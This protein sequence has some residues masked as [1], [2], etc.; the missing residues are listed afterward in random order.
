MSVMKIRLFMVTF[1][2]LAALRMSALAEAALPEP[3]PE[4]GGLR[5]RL[6]IAPRIEAG[7]EGY[8]V[9]VEAV[10][11]AKRAI[12]LRAGWWHETEQGD[13]KD[14]IEA[15][16]SIESYPAIAPWVGQVMAGH[17]QSPQPE[18]VLKAGEMLSVRWQTS[19][20]R[21]KNRVTDPNAVQNPEF[22][23]P[24]L[25]SV[26]AM[27]TI[28]TG[29]GAVLLRSNEQLVSFGGSRE[30]PKHTFGKLWRADENTKTA[31]L[32]LGSLHK[33]ERGD[34]FLIR[35]GML[36]FWKLTITEVSPESSTGRLEPEPWRGRERPAAE[37]LPPF[38]TRMMDATF[39]PQKAVAAEGEAA[40]GAS[41]VK[42]P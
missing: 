28:L 34:Q 3:G 12:T 1:F 6:V 13:V 4:A 30:N 10:N 39:I 36:D 32:G 7:Q 8:A 14:Y 15:A 16:T 9:R 37:R 23:A 26:H 29:D 17:R 35:T 5:L 11:V 42:K 31:M 21:L 24:G 40:T 20:R 27:V 2:V 38:P 41:Q 22:A 19:G 25:Y 33:I 18:Q